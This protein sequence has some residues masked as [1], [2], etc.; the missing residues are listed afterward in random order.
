MLST[1]DSHENTI[2]DNK[3][4]RRAS[5]LEAGFSR[6]SPIKGIG[7]TGSKIGLKLNMT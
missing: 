1:N 3:R 6:E 7:R 4:A 5:D 2:K